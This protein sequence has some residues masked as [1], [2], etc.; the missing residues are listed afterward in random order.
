[1]V[2]TPI[3]ESWLT[4]YMEKMRDLVAAGIAAGQSVEK[5]Q[6]DIDM[7]EYSHWVD[8]EWVDLNVLGMYHFLTD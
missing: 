2:L 7:E 6:R 5:M 8:F 4:D 3:R 1:M